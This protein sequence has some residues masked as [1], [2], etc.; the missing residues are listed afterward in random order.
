MGSLVTRGLR[1]DG[2]NV[3]LVTNGIDA[4]TAFRAEQFAAAAIDVMLPEVSGFEIC[5]HIRNQGSTLP[6]LLRS[7]CGDYRRSRR[8]LHRRECPNPVRERAGVRH[9]L[10][11]CDLGRG[12]RASHRCRPPFSRHLESR[13]TAAAAGGA[14]CTVRD[15]SNVSGGPY[16]A[17]AYLSSVQSA[18]DQAGF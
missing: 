16:T 5:R 6:V 3:T 12:G 7:F 10:E 4:L 15:V 9:D 2:Y 18:L 13:G 1:E 8:H 14:C 11:R 17:Q